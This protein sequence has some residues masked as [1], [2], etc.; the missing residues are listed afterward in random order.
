MLVVVR[1]RVRCAGAHSTLV[2]ILGVLDTPKHISFT[3]CTVGGC[4]TALQFELRVTKYVTAYAE[5]MLI[6]WMPT[7]LAAAPRTTAAQKEFALLEQAA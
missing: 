3:W 6:P 4:I 1:L 7:L 2:V 5:S